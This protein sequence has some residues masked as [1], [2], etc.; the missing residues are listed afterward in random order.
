MLIAAS[1]VTH[2]PRIPELPGL[3]SFAGQAFHSARWDHAAITR[4]KRV[5][6]VGTGSTAVQLVAALVDEGETLSLFQRTAQWV[7]PQDNQRYSPEQRAEFREQPHKL[8]ALR[9]FLA[10]RFAENFSNAV[11]DV[12]SP[13]LK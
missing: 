7:M 8:H 12:S 9:N 13:A 6:I 3:A 2:H 5:G 4:G 10:R 11:V 1:G